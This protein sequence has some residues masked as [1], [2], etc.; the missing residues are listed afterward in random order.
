[1]LLAP[2]LGFF[3]G[4]WSTSISS[5]AAASGRMVVGMQESGAKRGFGIDENTALFVEGKTARVIGEYGVFVFDLA[6]VKVDPDRRLVENIGVSYADN[7][8]SCDLETGEVQPGPGKRPVT[9]R[10]ITYEAPSRSLRNVFGAYTLYDLLA[11]LVLGD[12]ETYTAD[13]ARAIE[14]RAGY[15]TSVEISP[16]GGRALAYIPGGGR[17]FHMTAVDFQAS[18]QTRQL[19]AAQLAENRRA[20]LSHDYGAKPGLQART[21]MLGSA[22]L[23]HGSLLLEELAA[24]CEGRWACSPPLPPNPRGRT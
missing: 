9:Q 8:D 18:M 2:G 23:E 17:D 24:R 5:S 10:D 7:G 1:M 16:K 11:R 6:E 15:A 12:P 19:N 3:H 4:A 22:P 20:A 13:S 14:P 21:L